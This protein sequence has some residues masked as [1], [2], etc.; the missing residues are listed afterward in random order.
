MYYHANTYKEMDWQAL[1]VKK[2]ACSAKCLKT[3]NFLAHSLTSSIEIPL[4]AKKNCLSAD[5]LIAACMWI[6]SLILYRYNSTSVC[7]RATSN[8]FQRLW[9]V[10]RTWSKF[11]SNSRLVNYQYTCSYTLQ[12]WPDILLGTCALQGK[13]GYT[14]SVQLSLQSIYNCGSSLPVHTCMCV[15]CCVC[16]CCIYI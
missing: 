1:P 11:V 14:V 15:L 7:N 8:S 12:V 9:K 3:W 2:L 16:V 10:R 6:R 5:L 4:V 13:H